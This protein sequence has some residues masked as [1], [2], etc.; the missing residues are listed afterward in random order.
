MKYKKELGQCFLNN[1]IIAEK[2]V[3]KIESNEN[4]EIIEI[5]GG[6]GAL[7][8]FLISI[9]QKKITVLELD[10]SWI[11]FL[12]NKFKNEKNL[13][14]VEVNALNF[15][16]PEN[17]RGHMISNVPYYISY[18]IINKIISWRNK[19]KSAILI[20]QDEVAK[21]L[22]SE[23]ESP[24]SVILQIFFEIKIYEKIEKND[25]FPIPNIF[26]RVIKLIPIKNSEIINYEKFCT[27]LSAIYKQPRKTIKNNIK[28]SIYEKKFDENFLLKRAQELSK[29]EILELW[30]K[31]NNK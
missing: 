14:I 3:S 27:F 11:S 24:I 17:F 15:N 23:S 18:E 10:P 28:G 22:H 25:C 20:L 29:K 4:D 8:K 31:I 13:E 7:T 16:L 26:S 1:D 9:P 6:A 30:G 5:G 21:K 12:K 19:I 2:V